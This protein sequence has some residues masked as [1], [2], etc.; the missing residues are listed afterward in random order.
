MSLI[1]A[2]LSP[3]ASHN[4]GQD[5]LWIDSFINNAIAGRRTASGVRVS[6]HSA[7]QLS[8]YFASIRNI[9]ED[10]AKL[11]LNIIEKGKDGS[12]TILF[13]HPSYDLLRFSPN[14]EY[15]SMTF[16]ETLNAHAMASGNGYAEIVRN[17]RDDP[18]ELFI[19][20][21][22]RVTIKR[23]KDPADPDQTKIVYDIKSRLNSE[24]NKE[25]PLS[26]NGE[27][28]SR[29][30]AKDILHIH[31]LGPDGIMG[32][33]VAQLAAESLGISIAQQRFAASYYGNG[34]HLGGLLEFPGK[35]STDA[36][37]RV[38]ESWSEMHQGPLKAHKPAILENGMKFQQLG[39]S[40]KDSQFIQGREFQVSEIARWF[41]IPPHKIGDL[42][43]A[44]FSNIEQQSIEYVTDALVPWITRWEQEIRRKLLVDDPR[45]VSAKHNINALL[46][47]DMSTRVTFY[48]TLFQLGAIKP[49]EIRALEDLNPL[50]VD[51]SDK[52]FMQLNMSTLED[53][54]NG[55][56]VSG[57][58]SGGT[59]AAQLD[60]FKPMMQ[61]AALKIVSK[62]ISA[63]K[64]ATIRDK[65]SG[66]D[67]NEWL[68][69]FYSKQGDF[70]RESFIPLIDSL[71]YYN[72]KALK[73]ALDRYASRYSSMFESKK[74]D[75]LSSNAE[76][77]DLKLAHDLVKDICKAFLEMEQA[78]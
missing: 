64:K 32:W 23:I 67:M 73:V 76:D 2:L 45:N 41:R 28:T 72:P 65:K 27:F 22:T 53:I 21:P 70:I 19:I 15:S 6:P 20:H 18:V 52:T 24:F 78:L 69:D 9:S 75:I 57:A 46:R 62:E 38:R 14:P 33:S 31:G 56:G 37:A 11:P 13:D 4:P 42:K 43:K 55:S 71:D 7:N 25:A 30:D 63:V 29:F 26:K 40:P 68:P 10:I 59:L 5:A 47:G 8:A 1:K 48:K 16:R 51:G 35:L 12:T 3:M 61:N 74:D 36:I 17:G 60:T 50:N 34:T 49:D 58:N 77:F 54:A 44:T 39:V 66:M